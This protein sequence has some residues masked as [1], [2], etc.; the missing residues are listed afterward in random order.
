M[1]KIPKIRL[2]QYADDFAIMAAD[3]NI[4]LLNR[5]LQ[6]GIIEFYTAIC[7]L[8]LEININKTKTIIMGKTKQKEIK[9][10]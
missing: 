4:T 1:N 8:K 7:E 3:K 2:I 9:H 10:K 5:T 6:I